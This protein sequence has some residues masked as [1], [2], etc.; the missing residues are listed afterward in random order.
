[1]KEQQK[2]LNLIFDRVNKTPKQWANDITQSNKEIETI[3]KNKSFSLLYVIQHIQLANNL[4]CQ[5]KEN[6]A[7]KSLHDDIRYFKKVY[8]IIEKMPTE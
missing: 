3:L 8:S 7:I 5:V 2:K 1:M 6:D 4:L